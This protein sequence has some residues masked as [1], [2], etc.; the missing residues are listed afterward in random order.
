M[1]ASPTNGT[2]DFVLCLSSPS[3]P[4]TVIGK[5]G[6]WSPTTSE[7]GLML[8]RSHWHH[9]YMAEALRALLEYLWRETEVGEVTAD[10]DPR[11]EAC[12]GLLGK[13]GFSETGREE[14][15]FEVGG[16][17]CGSVYFRVERPGGEGG[18]G[19]G[20]NG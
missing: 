12:V 18:G 20:A 1:L 11:N 8:H 15:T 6:I 13:M 5:L 16:R 9:G 14:R 2:L 17:W 3:C 19:E 7:L 10:V 4:P